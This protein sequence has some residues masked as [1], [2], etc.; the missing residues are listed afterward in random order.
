[1]RHLRTAAVIA[2]VAACFAFAAAAVHAARPASATGDP[3]AVAAAAPIPSGTGGDLIR[4]G[5]ELITDTPK[6]AGAYIKAGMSCS[7]CHIA[8]GTKP[9]AGSF[10]GSYATYPRW[11]ARAKRFI[12]VQDRVAECFLY[13][14]NGRPPAYYSR[15]MI[16]MTAYIAW[17]SRGAVVGTGF[18]GQELAA[19]KPAHPPDSSAG[20]AIY[21]TKCQA[22]H[23][24]DGAGNA[25]AN[26]PPLWGATSFNDGAGFDMMDTRLAPWVR[27]NMPLGAPGS[28]SDQ[29]ASDVAAYVLSKPRPHFDRTTL[30]AFPSVPAG[31]F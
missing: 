16:A 11:N 28:L 13:S 18:P 29:E 17:L 12:T 1:V 26:F 20:A 2:A 3:A 31:F 7:A 10:L 6:Y 27:A 30:I 19:L 23:G 4:Y 8:A 25:A 21:A 5:K 9:Y 15:R 22:C 24:A 14:M